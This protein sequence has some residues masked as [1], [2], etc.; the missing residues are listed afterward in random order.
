M[1]IVMI[2]PFGLRPRMT[3]TARA[4]P[5]AKALVAHGHTVALL[6]P[7]WQNPEDA[8]R[9]W[10][11]AGVHIEN[12]PLPTGVPG[13]FHQ[14]LT[15]SLTRRARA[16]KPDVIHAFKP[17]A[18]A[19]LAHMA[20]AKRFPV[21]VDTDDW[22]GAGGWNTLSPYPAPLK[23][24]F[25]W[26]ERWGL[27]RARAVTVASRALQ[28][29]VWATGRAPESVFYIPNGVA[30]APAETSVT[31]NSPDPPRPTLLLYTRFFEFKV[32]RLWRV[33]C[34]VRA[35]RP[36]VRLLVAGKG[37]FGEEAQLLDLARA[38][39]WR[40]AETLA[41]TAAD[42]VYPG[43]VPAETLPAIF[44]QATLA[45]YPFDDTLLNRT[46]CPVKLMDLLA[47]GV[48]V[49]ADAVGQIAEAIRPGETGVLIPPGDETANVA[50]ILALLNDGRRREIG[51]RAAQD[52]RARFAWDNLARTTEEA[53]DYAKK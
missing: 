22:E 11:E 30:A 38:Q 17:K 52:V 40:I 53:Y 4:L 45:L 20:L 42:L 47:A 51:Q 18:Y 25:A 2:G 19:G 44:S 6:L 10:D 35:T 23:A 34:A 33:V 15:A 14:Q 49:V 36:D 24:F 12:M 31:R 29:L 16:L 1:N 48:P 50:A 39:G 27:T 46:K 26:Q 28:T 9:I 3:M 13:W 32:A 37:L 5:L 21:V 43:W 41:D 8:G 7:P